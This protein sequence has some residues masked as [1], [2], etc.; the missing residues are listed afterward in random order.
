MAMT[1]NSVH[2]TPQKELAATAVLGPIRFFALSFGCIVGSGWVVVLGDWLRA[3]GPVGTVLGML[4]G[5]SIMLANSGAYAE[6]ISAYPIAGGEFVF[7]QRLFGDRTAFLVG[8]LYTLS[9]ISVVAFE[10]TALPWILEALVPAIKGS[11][12]YVS[13]GSP[14]TSDAL[15]IGVGGTVVVAVMNHFGAGIAATMQAVLSFAF[16]ALALLLI[17]LGFALGSVDNWRPFVLGDHGRPWWVGALW[18][19]ATAPLFLNGFQSVAQAVEER[20]Q[21]VTF[22]RIAASMACAL[23]VS[24]SFYCLV[25]L[26]AAGAQPW[27][28]LLYK[29]LATAAAFGSL[30]PH[31][32]LATLVLVAAALSVARMWNGVSIWA[33]KLLLAQARAGFLPEIF[34][35]TNQRYGSP[36]FALM[37][38][39]VCSAVGVAL[40]RGAIIPLVD[41]ASLCLAG[42]LVLACVAA[43]RARASGRPGSY[44]TPGG[45]WTLLYALIGTGGM[46]AF[47]VVDP[48]LR[49]PDHIPIEWLVTGT[50]ICVGILFWSVW[51]PMSR[52]DPDG[53]RRMLP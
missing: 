15:L 5:G 30:L 8:W 38:I 32:V 27:Q 12:L 11:T 20:S 6:L 29:P 26:A 47:I 53:A 45:I 14:V 50:W 2:F 46:A 21:N 49:R 23:V 36:T 44:R 3:C 19:F 42:N 39:A 52:T 16:F 25:T 18:I 4:A 43:L 24:I 40:G 31:H 35:V 9:L 28:A 41:M 37:F 34:A 13:L 1:P 10:A 22:P 33:A 48:L 17:V 51:R 7:A